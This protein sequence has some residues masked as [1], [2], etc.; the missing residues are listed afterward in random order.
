MKF[1]ASFQYIENI[2]SSKSTSSASS[3]NGQEESSATP[4]EPTPEEKREENDSSDGIYTVYIKGPVLFTED[5]R[6]TPKDIY[7]SYWHCR[8]ME[9]NNLWQRS[10]V[11]TAFV[12]LCFTAYGGWMSKCVLLKE[13]VCESM[14]S[15]D[16]LTHLVALSICLVGSILARFW[17]MMAKASKSWYEIY[18]NAITAYEE[19]MKDEKLIGR[20]NVLFKSFNP[21][22]MGEK[23]TYPEVNNKLSSSMGGAF[24]PS[25]INWAIGHVMLYVWYILILSHAGLCGYCIEMCGCK[26]LF[27]VIFVLL[28]IFLNFLITCRISSC[29]CLRS[30]A[31][32]R[33]ANVTE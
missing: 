20:G 14:Q 5:H 12:I 22:D 30:E 29:G 26:W 31:I 3:S 27:C 28:A 18:E 23:Y 25:R 6:L 17:I 7:H 8:D 32:K 19:V 1:N 21:Q 2:F 9:I 16:W 15:A 10:V 24:S 33:R 4:Q 11:L 13:N